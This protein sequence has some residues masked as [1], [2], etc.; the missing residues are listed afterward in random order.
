MFY[1]EKGGFVTVDVL[2]SNLAVGKDVAVTKPPLKQDVAVT[3]P[4][5]KQVLLQG[6]D[7]AV[8]YS[9]KTCCDV[10]LSGFAVTRVL[11]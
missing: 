3:K 11:Q 1:N 2:L 5:L 4:P 6:K 10:L 7:A 8:I 9:N